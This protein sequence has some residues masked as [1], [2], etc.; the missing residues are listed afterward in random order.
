MP[1]V[2]MSWQQRQHLEITLLRCMAV[3]LLCCNGLESDNSHGNGFHLFLFQ[4]NENELLSDW[5]T[6]HASVFGPSRITIIDSRSTDSVVLDVLDHWSKL[7]VRVIPFG[8]LRPYSHK[9]SF[10]SET[11]RS[12]VNNPDDFLVPLDADE[13]IVGITGGNTF[14]TDASVIKQLISNLPKDGKRFK[15]TPITAG[16]CGDRHNLTGRRAIDVRHFK[17]LQPICNSKTFFLRS[18]FLQTDQGN[19]WGRTTVDANCTASTDTGNLCPAHAYCFHT[20]RLGLIHMGGAAAMSYQSYRNKM[21]RAY[22]A[23]VGNITDPDCP[24]VHGRHYCEFYKRWKEDG[25]NHTEVL[26]N[27]AARLSGCG[28]HSYSLTL[29]GALRALEHG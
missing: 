8:Q 26:F 25:D 27:T 9:A 13:F 11:M 24:N 17:I 18:S 3:V 1:Q 15:L 20:T 2:E 19:H 10:L 7:G 28:K 5:V 4:N 23:Y 21:L 16:Y 6:Y 29:A 12:I 14:S 22:H